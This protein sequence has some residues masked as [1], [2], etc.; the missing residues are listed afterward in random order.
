MPPSADTSSGSNILAAPKRI[1]TRLYINGEFRD[2]VSGK[3]FTLL[4]PA[5]DESVAQVAEADEEDVNAAV[6]AAEAAFPAWRDMDG[7]GR[8]ACL[9][10][11]AALIRENAD[12]FA[13]LEAVSMGR[14][15]YNYANDCEIAAAS[16]E[17]MAGAIHHL[18]GE[19]SLQ[20]DGYLNLTLRQPFGVCAA[21][22]PWN[23]PMI[24]FAWK[25][26]P[27]L[28]AG[29]TLVL[30]SSEKAPLTSIKMAELI[31]QAGFPP[32]VI[33][34]IAGF[35]P[36]AGAP[37]A[38]HMKVRKIAFTGS[39]RTGKLIQEMATQSNLK[40]VTLELGGKSPCV[41]FDDADIDAAVAG[42]QFSIQWNSGQI[43]IANSRIYVHEKIAEEFTRKFVESFGS[44]KIGNPLDK[45]TRHGPQADKIQLANIKRFLEKGKAE[46]GDLLLGG[47][48]V[49]M[50]GTEANGD[51]AKGC[52]VH[53]T[54]FSNVP[55]TATILKEEIFG[56]VTAI[57]TFTSEDEVLARCNDTEYGLYAAVYT[58]S[59][60][61]AIKFAKGMEAGTIGVNCTSPSGLFVD[62]PFGGFKQSGVGREC[63]MESLHHWSEVKTVA[64]KL[65]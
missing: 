24:M 18:H 63:G 46:G 48:Q 19:T 42:S 21:I 59:L 4:N 43:C 17:Y 14:P 22:I 36:T 32:G 11:L 27:C 2:A 52:F 5:T 33:N 53:P 7:H 28:A 20:S 65:S 38:K 64:I 8:A 44:V 10:K 57:N 29:N 31:H 26:G 49:T 30:K 15:V 1:E 40:N 41:V 60:D 23:V 3:T 37:M 54:V 50:D 16:I 12:A 9:R 6:D 25:L 35:G 55:E 34:I 45:D 47:A 62:M 56:P 51:E 13:Y 39:A 58:K 61:R